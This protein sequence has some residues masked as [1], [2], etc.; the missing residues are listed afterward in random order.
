LD[1]WS[2][3][4]NVRN[5]SRSKTG[6]PVGGLVTA[7]FLTGGLLVGCSGG[8]GGSSSTAARHLG[9]IEALGSILVNGVKF[10]TEGATIVGPDT[11]KPGMVVKVD[12]T[13]NADGVTGTAT[14]VEFDDNVTGPIVSVDPASDATVTVANVMGQTVVFEDNLTK[15]DATTGMPIG[16]DVN[17]VLRISGFERDDGKIQATF[18]SEV[19]AGGLLEVTGTVTNLGPTTFTINSLTIDFSGVV[20][21]DV[22]GGQLS[23]GLLVEVK[24]SNFDGTTLIATDIEGKVAGVGDDDFGKVH[25]EG[26]VSNLSGDTFEINGQ[27]VDASNATFR[28]GDK[29]DLV[30]GSKVEAEGPLVNGVVIAT[31]ITFKASVRLEAQVESITGNTLTFVGLP[32]IAVGV[33]TELTRDDANAFPTLAVGNDVKVRARIGAYDLVATRLEKTGDVTDR[34]IIRGP[35]TAISGP[36]VTILNTVTVDTSSAVGAQTVLP[37]LQVGNIVKARFRGGFWDQ[38]ELELPDDPGTL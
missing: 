2:D 13:V 33:H 32:G 7:L 11:P 18:A 37:G 12:G 6:H 26:I 9:E 21:R 31:R 25:V 8:G 15:F 20:P 34:T 17:K 3:T 30:N 1:K 29:A 35:V 28:T 23:N 10:E 5:P 36:I 27:A 19:A 16:T 24:G 22:P 38:I 14:G 4:M